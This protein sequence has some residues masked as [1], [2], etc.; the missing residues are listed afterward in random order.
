M[1]SV[2]KYFADRGADLPDSLPEALAPLTK[3]PDQGLTVTHLFTGDTTSQEVKGGWEQAA[4]ALG[5]DLNA[6]ATDLTP[7]DVNEK[8]LAAVK[9]SDVVVVDG[10]PPAAL[11]EPIKAAKAAGV[12]FAIASTPDAPESVPGFGATPHGGAWFNNLGELAGYALLR[13]TKCQA[14]VASFG[15]PIDASNNVISGLE[16]VVKQECPDC[17]TTKTDIQFADLGSP[18]ATTAVVSK[19][20]SD[21]SINFVFCFFGQVATGVTAALKGAGL[22]AQIGGTLPATPNLDELQKGDN[23]FWVGAPL[24]VVGWLEADTVARALDAG[25]PTPGDV[26]PVSIYTSE[27][28]G[29]PGST[30]PVA[31]D[32]YQDAFKK[33]WL[34]DN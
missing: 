6:V 34:V 7:E 8:A 10:L 26:G 23:A 31:P 25:Q 29:D 19:L 28:V 5:W 12:L 21:P 32:G 33:L 11:Q 15:I 13:S 9:D 18:A 2:D 20:Q 27:N 4:S 3:T 24:P 14:H 17:T 22:D 1:D 30:V 16:E